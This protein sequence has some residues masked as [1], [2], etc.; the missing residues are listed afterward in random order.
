MT[1]R[2]GSFL[3]RGGL[4]TLAC[5]AVAALLTLGVA[6]LLAALAVWRSARRAPLVPPAAPERILVLGHRLDGA[7]PSAVFAARLAR[8]L[9]LARA[10]PAARVVALGGRGRAGVPSEAEAGRD[11]LAARGLDPGRIAVETASRHTL[12]NLANHRALFGTGAAEALVTSRLH[13]HRAV[14]MAR[15]L[16]L[17][18]MPVAAE[19]R[20]VAELARLAAEGFRVHWYLT[21]RTLAR[22][23]RRWTWLARIA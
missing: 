12:E 22:V 6:P 3:G 8:G 10:W 21:G 9:A 20:A 14:L 18:P 2:E 13:L 15:G 1:V 11:W 7:V 5:A 19:E 17:R 16:G 23:L 4:V